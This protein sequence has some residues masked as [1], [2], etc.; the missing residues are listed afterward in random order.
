MRLP[1][2]PPRPVRLNHYKYKVFPLGVTL[3]QTG[4]RRA[5][6]ADFLNHL[7]TKTLHS[8]KVGSSELIS[9]TR[10]CDKPGFRFIQLSF[11]FHSTFLF[12]KP[13]FALT[14]AL[15]REQPSSHPNP[16]LLPQGGCL[17]A[18][19]CRSTARRASVRRA[20]A[21]RAPAKEK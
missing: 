20:S 6:F 7:N 21:M 12:C 14:Q 9:Q 8:R 4:R 15:H 1:G 11:N 16:G 10:V 13:G 2:L 3:S 19:L 5:R 17:E 18:K